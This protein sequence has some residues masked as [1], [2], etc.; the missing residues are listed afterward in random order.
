MNRT[1][2]D[3]MAEYVF[4]SKYS[5]RKENGILENWNETVDRIY[6]M[7]EVK[8]KELGLFN[9]STEK[10]LNKA[11]EFEYNKVILSSQ[12][13]RQF[14]SSNKYSG[15][16][17]HEAKM[18]NCSSTFIDRP[19]VFSEIMYLLLCGCGV[20]YSLH[21]EYIEKLPEVKEHTFSSV[22][23][24]IPDSIEGWAD[25]I[26]HL[27]NGWFGGYQ[28]NFNYSEIRPEGSLIDGKFVAPGA[29]P[30]HD[31][32]VKINKIMQGAIG[33]KLQ[34][35]EIHDICC[36]IASSVVSGGVRRSAMIAMFD[37]DD[38]LMLKCK[39]GN[40][41]EENPQRAFAN[42]SILASQDE[43]ISYEEIKKTLS[44][45]RQFGEPGFINVP[46]Y[47]YVVNPCFT[48]DT[49]VAVANG[50]NGVSIKELA[51]RKEWVPMYYKKHT[52]S[53]G[54]TEGFAFC[55]GKKRVIELRLSDG[56][57]IHCT[58]NHR[59]MMKNGNYVNAE[60][61]VGKIL[62]KFY[63]SNAV[64]YRTINS[65]KNGYSR[66]YRMIW[67]YYNGEK[68]L[69][70]DIDHI[71]NSGGDFIQNL[72]L[73]DKTSHNSKSGLEKMGNNNP[74]YR[75][76]RKSINDYNLSCSTSL[77]NNGRFNGL[78]NEELIKIGKKV[79]KMGLP[80]T[81]STCK[82]MDSRWPSSFS[83][84]R[85][86]G[87]FSEFVKYVLGEK[88]YER[89][90]ENRKQIKINPCNKYKHLV[91]DVK[92]VSISEIGFE[93]VYD[94]CVRAD[95][96]NFAIITKTCDDDYQNCSGVFVHNCGEIVMK[97]TIDIRENGKLVHETGFAF[98]NLVEIN[99]KAI[100]DKEMFYEACESA[101]FIATVQSLYIDFKY[102]GRASKLIAKRDRAI[103]V[104]I[105]GFYENNNLNKD[106]LE[107]GAKLVT[108][109]NGMW[110]TL[111]GISRSAC[112][113]TVKPSG[114]ASC[115]LGLT[116]SG[117]HPAHDHKYL[118]RIRIKTYSPEYVALKDTPM[119]K[120]LR[121]DE[122]V[123][124]FPIE[125]GGSVKTKDEVFAVEHLKDI[126]MVKHFWINKGSVVKHMSNN[127][128]STVE[129][130]ENEWDEV[131]AVYYMNRHL[132][133]GV[134]FLPSFG[135]AVYDNAPFQ[136]LSNKELRKEYEE[137]EKYIKENDVDFNSIMSNRDN[138]Y[139]GDM[140]AQGCAGGACEL[141]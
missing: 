127:V 129:V 75:I 101:S 112:C 37:R 55:T 69:G 30:L 93:Y 8:L 76:K 48:G 7:H 5:Q 10:A 34:S 131:A 84:N 122:A 125:S 80:L 3:L 107:V 49:I 135:D 51:E 29:K 116:C 141:K 36:H 99:N 74:V 52:G 106:V 102:L 12:R 117:I 38:E 95:E 89:K 23:F 140:A 78:S 73:L 108:I 57:V 39:T 92:V 105:T 139:S 60:N 33:R 68:P 110:A 54:I 1:G 17:K 14:A 28:V 96:H 100:K 35:I 32:I 98:C 130:K 85:F 44:V 19:K 63:T 111:F 123:I 72:Q 86:G 53:V 81:F 114:N 9:D 40:W 61:S 109:K 97:P 6:G 115:I 67:E 126:A 94:I 45:V 120:Y 26:Y 87:K 22:L 88:N 64:K 137:I 46:S 31:A 15:I 41:W 136:R 104:S 82:S 65:F 25:A 58:P 77:E 103:G 70:Y 138:L 2:L 128:S 132:F 56:S 20:G 24:T 113:T 124:T 119:V 83:K 11:K 50:E 43:N 79:V 4:L 91:Q 121:G 16:L 21:K 47:D 133:T 18:Y 42:N 90:I 134:T 62:S 66:Q 13:G 71:D 118:R 59:I 27:M